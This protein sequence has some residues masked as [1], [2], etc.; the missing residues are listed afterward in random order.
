[1]RFSYP[2]VSLSF[3]IKF[4][5]SETGE[6]TAS[7]GKIYRNWKIVR[8]DTVM[9]IS[10]KDKGK[11]GLVTKVYRNRNQL[12]VEGLNKVKL[13]FFLKHFLKLSRNKKI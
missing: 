9:A 8:G 10:G 11:S 6:K 5:K 4:F 13:L 7:G 3:Q 2:Q 12:I 1:M